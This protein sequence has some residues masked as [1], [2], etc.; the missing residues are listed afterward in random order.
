MAR[1]HPPQGGRRNAAAEVDLTDCWQTLQEGQDS[2]EDTREAVER[3]LLRAQVEVQRSRL[4]PGRRRGPPRCLDDLV[5]VESQ[6]PVEPAKRGE[7]RR[8]PQPE[9]DPD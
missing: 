1:P 7:A 6:A 5:R 2:S 3:R 9:R 4:Q 8:A